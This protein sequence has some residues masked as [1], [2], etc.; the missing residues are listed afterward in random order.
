[1]NGHVVGLEAVDRGDGPEGLLLVT[2]MSVVTS[3][4]PVGSKNVPPAAKAS[5]AL[6]V[7]IAAGK[8]HGAIAAHTP[9]GSLVTTMRLSEACARIVSPWTHLPSSPNHSMKAA[10]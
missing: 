5:L 9:I 2:T 7:I 8:F 10:P 6:R 4:A 1:M 3:V